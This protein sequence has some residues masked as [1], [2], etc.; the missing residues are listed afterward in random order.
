[1]TS[2]PLLVDRETFGPWALV[3]G[4]SSGIGR[5]F[6]RQL[7]AHGFDLVLAARRGA[8]LNA[9]AAELEER[10]GV[11]CRPVVVDLARPGGAEAIGETTGDLDVG[12]VV[13]NAGTGTPGDFL[14]ADLEDLHAVIHL[15][16]V[17]HADLAHHFGRR[18]VR[19]G[20][21]GLLL[22]GALGALQGIPYMAHAGGTKAYVESL[23]NGLHVELRRHGVHVTVLV[24]GPTDTPVLAKF[25]IAPDELPM[26]PISAERCVAEALRALAANR[27][28]IVPGARMRLLHAVVPSSLS[29][30]MMARM[31]A[32]GLALKGG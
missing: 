8:E 12:L 20:R 21:G 10:R 30:R 28:T 2:Q 1:M 17:A 14:R 11:R 27:A 3:T 26:K 18:L 23:G 16:V 7:A 19:R 25:G 29:R 9:L 15:N 5:E 32:R 13:S 24:P 4:A 31:F 6:A 22:V